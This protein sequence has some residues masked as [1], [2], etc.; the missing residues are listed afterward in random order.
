VDAG[1]SQPTIHRYLNLLEATHLF[2]RLPAYLGS[3]TTRLLKSLRAFWSDVGLAVF[4]AGYYSADELAGARER[5]SFFETLIY[6]HLGV[7]AGLLTPRARLHFWRTQTGDEV[8]FVIEH[9]RRVLGIEVKMTDTPGYR[10][11]TGLASF[12]GEHPQA[13]GGMILHAGSH[14]RRLAENIVAV[15]WRLLTW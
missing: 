3:H 2:P 12:L 1:L 14:V 9:G 8:D 15:P 13:V 10:H 4:L 5:G 11:A 7:S 6:Q